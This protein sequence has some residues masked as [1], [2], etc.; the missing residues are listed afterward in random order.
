MRQSRVKSGQD[1][2][3]SLEKDGWIVKATS[4][5]LKWIGE[6]YTNIEKIKNCKQDPTKLIL[7]E[8]ESSFIK[9]DIIYEETNQVREA[10]KYTKEQL[11]GWML[12]SEPFFK[13][14]SVGDANKI[15]KTEY[16]SFAE[17]FYEY[18]LTTGLFD[19]VMEN[20]KNSSEGIE[21]PDGFIPKSD[22]EY[23]T[24]LL[25]FNWLGYHRITIQCRLKPN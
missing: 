20:M 18:N 1:F 25:K 15:S 23:R 4:P 17:K 8:N 6:G 10:K 21:T 16:N 12:Y 24:V 3:L 14:A 9:Y 13:I 22:I 5:R 11:K 19:R 7:N 2:E